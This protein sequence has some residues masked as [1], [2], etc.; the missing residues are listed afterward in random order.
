MPILREIIF[1]KKIL[2]FPHCVAAS[3]STL[4]FFWWNNYLPVDE[5][6][7]M[8]LHNCWT[9][10]DN[11]TWRRGRRGWHYGSDHRGGWGRWDHFWGHWCGWSWGLR[12]IDLRSLW[13]CNR[14]ST[15]HATTKAKFMTNT[16]KIRIWL[17]LISKSTAHSTSI[18]NTRLF[19]VSFSKSIWKI[20]Y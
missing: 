1:V 19:K 17:K 10:W 8:V 13:G 6:K 3:I 2:K 14:P 15:G 16:Y 5:I 7:N 20:Q 11:W 4:V 18:S 12:T 9:I